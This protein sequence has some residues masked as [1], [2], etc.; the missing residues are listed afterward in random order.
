[1]SNRD[2]PH[3]FRPIRQYR[4]SGR[5]PCHKYLADASTAS[6][7]PGD[8]LVVATDGY[9]DR[10]NNNTGDGTDADVNIIGVAASP[11]TTGTAGDVWVYDDPYTVFEVQGDSTGGDEAKTDVGA[12]CDALDT[13]SANERSQMELDTSTSSANTMN[14]KILR[15]YR[16]PG[17]VYGTN[18]RLEV[19][20][21]EHLLK[22]TAGI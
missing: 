22:D 20:L 15:R 17:S 1:M 3:G 19:L 9:L 14:L 7:E 6:L 18:T 8:L 12:C 16:S 4:R 21:N 10:F 13:A 11:H 5:I 2:A